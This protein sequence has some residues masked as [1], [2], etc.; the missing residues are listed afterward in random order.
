ME[1][2]PYL[3]AGPIVRRVE[4]E[5]VC[6]W[7]ASSQKPELKLEL[8]C[9]GEMIET[10]VIDTP[11][12]QL[13]KNASLWITLLQLAPKQGAV[14]PCDQVIQYKIHNNVTDECLDLSD[15]TFAGEANPSFIIPSNL[16]AIAYGSCR[17]PHGFSQNDED[18]FQKTDS[19]AL[20]GKNIQEHLHDV[21]QRPSTLCLIGDQIYAD[22]VLDPVMDLLQEQVD[23]IFEDDIDLPDDEINVALAYEWRNE[24]KR[25]SGLSSTS[26][27]NHLLSFGEYTAMY[28]FVFGNRCELSTNTRLNLG[29]DLPKVLEVVEKISPQVACKLDEKIGLTKEGRRDYKKAEKS[30]NGFIDSLAEVRKVFANISTYMIFDDHDVSDDWNITRLWYDN[31]RAS[32]NG[33]RIVSNALAAYW[34]FQGWGNDPDKFSDEFIENV[35]GYLHEPQDKMK[36]QLFDFCLWKSH[37]W[38]YTIPATPPILVL[39]NRTQR[40]FGG[41]NDPPQLLNRYGTDQL[42]GDWLRLNHDNPVENTP[43]IIA[44]TPV[45]GYSPIEKLQKLAYQIGMFFGNQTGKFTADYLDLESWIANKQGFSNF[46]NVLLRNMKLSKAVFLSGDVHYSF[47]HEGTYQ[48]GGSKLTYMQLTSS[49][50]RNTPKKP[51]FMA[52]FLSH[53]INTR[54]EGPAYPEVLPWWERIFYIWRLFNREHWTADVRCTSGCN[55]KNKMI[56]RTSRPNIGLIY[57]E[58]GE[59]SKQ[60][61]LSGDDGDDSIVYNFDK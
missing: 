7:L 19:L 3:L 60:I 13:G 21:S 43:L 4:K 53:K 39:D 36:S 37:C 11:A 33:T 58:K 56:G 59:V 61:L 14:F 5:K 26:K 28:L 23:L 10:Q 48:V 27:N 22:D 16:N 38:S 57:F 18:N 40:D 24:I 17:K 30:L 29:R 51:R 45:F 15:V 49:A 41:Y 12:F 47:V 35:M 44:P 1:S 2:L 25:K 54:T 32:R 6:I 46:L 50:L 8:I 9:N 31:V 20:L 34:A 55:G 42:R 52:R